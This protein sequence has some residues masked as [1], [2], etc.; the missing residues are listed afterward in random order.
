VFQIAIVGGSTSNG[1]GHTLCGK[2]RS[3]A[4]GALCCGPGYTQR[5]RSLLEQGG[6]PVRLH[7]RARGGTGPELITLCMGSAFSAAGMDPSTIDLFIVEYAIN[8]GPAMEGRCERVLAKADRLLW[9]IRRHAPQAAIVLLHT[10]SLYHFIDASSCWDLLATYYGLP[11]L[12][13]RTA[14]WPLLASGALS[15]SDMLQPTGFHHPNVQGHRLM[16]FML[17]QLMVEAEARH[18]DIRSSS[19]ALPALPT[20]LPVI[21]GQPPGKA[22]PAQQPGPWPGA[23]KRPGLIRDQGMHEL[24]VIRDPP[25]GQAL[26]AQP[27]TGSK[28]PGL[29]DERM[30]ALLLRT[31]SPQCATAG[32]RDVEGMVTSNSGWALDAP[33]AR[34]YRASE[35]NATLTLRVSCPVPTGCGLSVGLSTSYQPLG[36]L[37]MLVDGRLVAERSQASAAL[38]RLGDFVTIEKFE[39][40]L[41][42]AAN[43]SGHFAFGSH[44]LALRAKGESAAETASWWSNYSRH[45]VH[46][47]SLVVITTPHDCVGRGC[48]LAER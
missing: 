34:Y 13:L 45:E 7:N 17:L 24:P 3:A 20:A 44:E 31:P 14:L 40:L 28:R 26:L 21:R 5:L 1:G 48:L 37:Q 30:H 27:G 47:R 25:P 43:G 22:L 8:T 42:M 35:P 33:S 23:G 12:S 10:Y 9:R 6:L 46:F 32:S 18:A 11:S 38:R 4:C 2:R 19:L 29:V 15:P 16:A 41:P 39:N 36:I